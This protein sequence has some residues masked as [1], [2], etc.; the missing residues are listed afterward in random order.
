MEDEKDAANTWQ[1]LAIL[2]AE[3]E[4]ILQSVRGKKLGAGKKA[5][6]QSLQAKSSGKKTKHGASLLS[7]SASASRA[8]GLGKDTLR[9]TLEIKDADSPDTTP[10]DADYLQ[11]D[12]RR[13]ELKT[14]RDD[15]LRYTEA[16]V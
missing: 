15:K 16:R 12:A 4:S 6:Q 14:L 3:T 10:R 11:A 9:L 2:Q 7:K 13:R 1:Q 5:Q 8:L